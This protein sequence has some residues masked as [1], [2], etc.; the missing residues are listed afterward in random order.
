[1]KVTPLRETEKKEEKEEKKNKYSVTMGLLR[2]SQS[3]PEF[4]ENAEYA[5]RSDMFGYGLLKT[6]P[7][8][9]PCKLYG[10][11][12]SI[13]ERIIGHYNQST[14]DVAALF[15][16]E[17]G[18][19]KTLTAKA[20]A[21]KLGLPIIEINSKIIGT[22]LVDFITELPRCVIIID[23]VEK[24]S[25]DIESET[26]LLQM[27]DAKK[28]EPKLFLLS[29]NREIGTDYVKSR[30]TR[31]FYKIKFEKLSLSQIEEIA[32][33]LL[34][35]KSDGRLREFME[36]AGLIERPNYDVIKSLIEEMN[37]FKISA[38]NAIKHM[39]IAKM[40][41]YSITFVINDYSY[42]YNKDG[43]YNKDYDEDYDEDYN[44]K[45]RVKK[46]EIPVGKVRAEDGSPIS[47]TYDS[48]LITNALGI[49]TSSS[50][51]YVV[52][53]DRSD[54]YYNRANKAYEH[55][56]CIGEGPSLPRGVDVKILMRTQEE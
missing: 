48:S 26:T 3:D 23:E 50:T 4:L 2:V 22:G 35:D 52:S 51:I 1:M 12:N 24:L 45:E 9:L 55:G 30:P 43:S 17:K 38:A 19:G 34:S 21:L 15:I 39:N 28:G 41:L 37:R 14:K 42:K 36:I 54:A 56:L 31:I 49:T 5:V 25:K 33:D 13:I 29:A 40:N 6:P 7:T 27:L 11:N 53:I 20:I 16:G 47:F 10:E 46:T 18:M 8:L 32:Q 44:A